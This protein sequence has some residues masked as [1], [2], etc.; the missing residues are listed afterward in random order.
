[1]NLN[2]AFYD[3]IQN[4]AMPFYRAMTA[5]Q[6]QREQP[7]PVPLLQLRRGRAESPAWYMIQTAEFAPEPLT[8]AKLRVR[9]IYASESITLA[10]LELLASETWLDRRGDEYYLTET[11]RAVMNQLKTRAA[12]LLQAVTPPTHVDVGRLEALLRRVIEAS[13]ACPTPPGNWCL[14]YSRR[15]A[16]GEEA[17]ALLKLYHYIADFNAFRDDAHMAAWQPLGVGGY[18][19]EAFSFVAT[20]Q[21]ET[22]VALF[23]QLAYRGYSREDYTA[24][25][26]NLAGR[27]WLAPT[28]DSYQ[29]TNAG[30]TIQFEVEQHTDDYFYTPWRQALNKAELTETIEQLRLLR[31]EWQS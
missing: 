16:P 20:G 18:E 26:Q 27:G 29:L 19:W 30:R 15:R 23:H 10:L 11:G 5:V 6:Q 3:D 9:D 7:E 13:L 28:N 8:V 4:T 14:A 25:L 12:D 1:M 24:S 17:P 31:E 2:A 21:A 22:A